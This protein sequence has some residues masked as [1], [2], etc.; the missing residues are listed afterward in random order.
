MSSSCIDRMYVND[1]LQDRGGLV[2]S[3]AGTNM[4]DQC[5]NSTCVDKWDYTFS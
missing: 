4:S 3:L 1:L 5:S 2:F